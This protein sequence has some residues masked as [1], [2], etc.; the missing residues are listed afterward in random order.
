[1]KIRCGKSALLLAFLF[2]F[3]SMVMAQVHEAHIEAHKQAHASAIENHNEAHQKA[4]E[5]HKKILE[6][7]DKREKDLLV[8]NLYF[9]G[10]KG[11]ETKILR[12]PGSFIIVP[13]DSKLIRYKNNEP[14]NGDGSV[15][16]TTSHTY[17]ELEFT[18]GYIAIRLSGNSS[19]FLKVFIDGD[20]KGNFR[21]PDN[22]NVVLLAR[23]LSKQAHRLRLQPTKKG[24]PNI[25]IQ[26][27]ELTKKG[28]LLSF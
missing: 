23:G 2:L 4:I 10:E 8:L 21:V 22:E 11:S 16:I 18:G 17:A 5:T 25:K 24:N 7:F 15:S 1:M 12:N 20:Y 3:S 28:Q 6:N 13:A 19:S 14:S 9:A 27:F 26:S